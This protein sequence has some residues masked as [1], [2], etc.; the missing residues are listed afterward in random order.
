MLKKIQKEVEDLRIRVASVQSKTGT[1]LDLYEIEQMLFKAMDKQ[2]ILSDVG[3]SFCSDC[4]DKVPKEDNMCGA[5]YK[6]M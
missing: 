4:G 5:C 6:S 3:C 2:L 1:D